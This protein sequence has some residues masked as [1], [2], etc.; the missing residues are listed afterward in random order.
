VKY[1]EKARKFGDVLIVG[2]NSD[3]SVRR[4]KGPERPILKQEERAE[5]LSALEF[6]DYILIFNEENVSQHLKQIMP[7]V[8]VKGGDYDI[9]RIDQE[10]KRVLLEYQAT[11]KFVPLI[12]GY[13]SSDIMKKI[14]RETKKK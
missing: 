6:V 3:E 4:L 8:Y 2:L 10:E 5:I 12:K 14:K 7:E 11:I 1:L 13:A 9:K